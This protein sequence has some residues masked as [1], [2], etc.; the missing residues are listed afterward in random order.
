[1]FLT[2][3]ENIVCQASHNLSN[4]EILGMEDVRSS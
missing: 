3:T 1:M 4:A 2:H